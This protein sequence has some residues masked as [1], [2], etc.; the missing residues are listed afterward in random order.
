MMGTITVYIPVTQ[1]PT[2]PTSSPSSS[3]IILSTVLS[4]L[5]FI[6]ILGGGRFYYLW[7]KKKSQVEEN[8]RFQDG[9]SMRAIA[10]DSK[11]G[12]PGAGI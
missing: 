7:R 4:V 2:A 8:Q 3:T 9:H 11:L 1:S 6:V 12:L 5:G 10:E